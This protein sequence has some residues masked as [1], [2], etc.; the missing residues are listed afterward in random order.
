MCCGR[1]CELL[2]KWGAVTLVA[3]ALFVGGVRFWL[4]EK[5]YVFSAE[6]LADITNRA[7]EKHKKSSSIIHYVGEV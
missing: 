2:L 5:H 4:S 7:L 3:S 6:E 1:T